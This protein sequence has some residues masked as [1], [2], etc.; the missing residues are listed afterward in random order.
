MVFRKKEIAWL[1]QRIAD[2]EAENTR[3]QKVFNYVTD[4]I[5]SPFYN[6]AV[7]S[8]LFSIS[9]IGIWICPSE[10]DILWISPMAREI[11]GYKNDF[12]PTLE[13]LK[14]SI[15]PEDKPVFD[16]ALAEARQGSKITE[17]ELKIARTEGDGR[18]F[19]LVSM[20]LTHIEQDVHGEDKTYGIAGCFKDITR[21]DKTKRDLIKAKEKAEEA[22]RLKN[23]LLANISH[24]IRTPMNSIIGFSE[25]LN[26]GNL[27]YNKR[28]EYVRTI[29]NQGI[30]LLK[31]IDDVVEL[32]R[33]ETGKATI[34]KSPCNIDLL[35]NELV[36]V[37]NRYK[38][39]QNKE[40]LEIKIKYPEN[41]GKV[42]ILTPGGF[43]SLYG[44]SSA[45][46][47]SIQRKAA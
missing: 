42:I 10:V 12:S 37:F 9:G 29:K 45:T 43:N 19:R 14:N 44:A 26:I 4:D 16:K 20:N 33:I 15:L 6:I 39:S 7:L 36:F 22:E 17:L 41:K 11:F 40:H 24:E 38:V 35:I 3:M 31:M 30:L 23:S 13:Q 21:Q 25:L 18:E 8:K 34:R 27:P 28:L 5:S 2:L 32:T 47:L 46:Q 1:K